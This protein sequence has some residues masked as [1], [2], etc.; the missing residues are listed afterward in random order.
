[1]TIRELAEKIGVSPATISIVL[2]NKKGVKD[3]TRKMVQDAI[4]KYNFVPRSRSKQKK[5]RIIVVEF[6]KTGSLIEENQGFIASIIET[7]EETLKNADYEVTTLVAKET[8][9]AILQIDDFAKYKGMILIASEITK[10]IYPSLRDITI[11]FVSVDNHMLDFS[12][13]SVCMNNY[14]NVLILLEYCQKLGHHRIGH[15]ASA[16]DFS[17]FTERSYYYEYCCKNLNIECRSEDEYTIPATLIGSCEEL[18]ELLKNAK[19]LPDCFFAD[20]DI[21]A[22]GAIKALK[23]LG[24]KVP[25]D[26][27]VVGF[28]DIPY[29]SISQ[30]ALTTIHVQKEVM[31]KQAVH[32]LLAQ[33]NDAEFVPVKSRVTGRLVIRESVKDLTRNQK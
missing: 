12:Y 25:E 1:M 7:V 13:N 14:E 29:A 24:Y 15:F 10:D 21:I 17:N 6:R 27:S 23:E 3:E 20:N 11:P 9:E 31:G 8:A 5:D 19:D 33:I 2:N 26:I 32:Q 16:D 22:L 18:K 28:D 30:P 4:K